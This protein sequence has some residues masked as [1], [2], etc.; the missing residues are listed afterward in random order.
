[1][2][3][4]TDNPTPLLAVRDLRT[5]FQTDDGLVRAVDGVSFRMDRGR[6]FALVGESG[7]GKSVTAF[8]ILRLLAMPPAVIL[9]EKYLLRRC[10][11]PDEGH[12]HF[13][14]QHIPASQIV[15]DGTSLLDLGEGQMRAVRGGHIGM[16]FQEQ[17]GR[18]HV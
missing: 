14:G 5:Y 2:I 18:A 9:S 11:P 13:L 12:Y 15:F 17:I 1:M 7:C 4:L 10:G 6:T 8:S 3:K 16:I